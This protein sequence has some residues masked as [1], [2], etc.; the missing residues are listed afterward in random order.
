MRYGIVTANLEE[1]AD[2]RVAVRLARAAE[3]AGWE[4][5]FVWDHLGFVRGVSSGDPWVILSTVADS[6]ER[7]KLGRAL[8]G[9]RTAGVVRVRRRGGEPC[10]A[11]H[12]SNERRRAARRPA[13]WGALTDGRCR[14]AHRESQVHLSTRESTR[15]AGRKQNRARTREGRTPRRLSGDRPRFEQARS[16]SS[17]TEVIC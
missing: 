4:A 14:R 17:S 13:A 1:Y 9:G 3:A 6:T 11:R 2:P 12:Q 10:T 15:G 16:I 8:K 7:L 5:F